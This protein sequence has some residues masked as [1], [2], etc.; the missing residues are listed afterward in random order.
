MPDNCRKHETLSSIRKFFMIHLLES[1]LAIQHF[2][3][4]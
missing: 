1:V 4:A 2:A 3:E